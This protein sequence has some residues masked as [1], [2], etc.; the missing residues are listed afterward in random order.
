M[1]E[2]SLRVAVVEDDK[3]TRESLCLLLG[4]EPTLAVAGAFGSGRELLRALDGL[5]A[6]VI[7]VDLGLPDSTG[8]ELIAA[9]KHR[10]PL[11]ELMAYTVSEDRDTVFGALRAGATGYILKGR[12]PRELVEALHA[13]ARGGSPMSPRIARAVVRAFQDPGA[14]SE[15]LTERERE[16]LRRIE[17]GSSYK[18][19][20]AELGISTNTVHTHIK[21]V[22][23][24]L[25]A[26][27]REE[28]VR[29]ARR[30]GLL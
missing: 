11:C 7:L 3:T 12:P 25:Q 27:S 28:A 19:V 4:G 5:E 14:A 1:R 20:A 16:V 23:E 18:E 26:R 8:A 30:K 9:V 29:V 17:R 21:H 13:L 2:P 10:R 24:K 22:Y 15:V 6:D